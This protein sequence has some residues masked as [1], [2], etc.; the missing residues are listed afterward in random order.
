MQFTHPR[1]NHFRSLFVGEH[2]ERWIFFAET[3][4]GF[5]KFFSTAAINRIHGNLDHR[6]RNVHVF[7]RAHFVFRSVSFTRRTVDP[8]DGNNVTGV[9]FVQLFTLIRV[10][11]QHA[12]ETILFTGTLIEVRFALLNGS[13]IDP[14][15]SQLAKGVFDDLERHADKRL[16]LVWSQFE[17]LIGIVP[18]L[19]DDLTRVGRRQVTYNRVQQSL[20]TL[21]LKR[22]AHEDRCERGFADRLSRVLDDFVDQF[23]VDLFFGQQLL[24]HFVVVHRQ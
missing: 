5:T 20:N 23:V 9:G 24:H 22:R 16:V 13:L 1:D 8:H 7:Q 2:A 19:G 21:V 17:W 14:H 10:H 12:T 4:K 3:L 6:I 11:S 15:V 18:L